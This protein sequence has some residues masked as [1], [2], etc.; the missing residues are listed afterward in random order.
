MKCPHGIHVEPKHKLGI[1]IYYHPNGK[2]CILLNASTVSLEALNKAYIT[3]N[4]P[5]PSGKWAIATIENSDVLD[6][7]VSY[8]GEAH[9]EEASR[10]LKAYER[11]NKIDIIKQG[12]IE[13][14]GR[15]AK[16]LFESVGIEMIAFYAN[17]WKVQP[18]CVDGEYGDENEH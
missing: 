13:R 7:V 18:K 10:V 1:D 16:V 6:Y 3:H 12:C 15:Y 11:A 8:I 9:L 5:D 2:K 4:H 14:F 17:E